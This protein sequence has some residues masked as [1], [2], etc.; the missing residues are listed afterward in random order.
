MLYQIL[1]TYN[2]LPPDC[3][4]IFCNTGK[5][6]LETL[7]FVHDIETKWNVPI[8]WLEYRY[9]PTRSGGKKNP[10]N[11]F[12][13]VDYE[14][15][16]RNGEPFD[17]LIE[18]KRFLPNP[19]MR[20]CTSELKVNTVARYLYHTK[21][22]NR[23]Q[24]QRIIGFRYDEPKRW[25]KALF[26]QCEMEFP[27][28]AARVTKEHINVFWENH[29]FDL[30]LDNNSDEGNCD[31]CFLKGKKKLIMLTRKR[32]GQIDWWIKKEKFMSEN[33]RLERG[34]M[35]QFAK[36]WSYTEIKEEALKDTPIEITEDDELGID[37][38]CT[39]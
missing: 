2:G 17:Q 5:E 37:C 10:K 11:H 32:P 36:R 9:D 1:Q 30:G 13:I 29:D 21:G 39:D 12:V 3:E 34:Y 31:K 25:H 16:S 19:V 4:V 22:L 6:Q 28:V 33:T 24:V 26:D 38:F 18:Q 7:D 27:M 20:V 14:T 23:N 35:T 8:T 15:A